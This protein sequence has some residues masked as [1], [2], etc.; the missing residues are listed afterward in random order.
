MDWLLSG[1]PPTTGVVPEV[2]C[3]QQ[4]IDRSQEISA[5]SLGAA[6]IRAWQN[7]PGDLNQAERPPAPAS[8]I[9]D[10]WQAP[11]PATAFSVGG[12]IVWSI[13]PH[14]LVELKVGRGSPGQSCSQPTGGISLPG[15]RR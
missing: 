9:S 12:R 3:A 7:Q 10:A 1:S 5:N 8:L 13:S 14:P 2:R 4:G 6:I 15:I 11:S